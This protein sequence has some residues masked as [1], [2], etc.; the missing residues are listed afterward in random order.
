V[1]KADGSRGLCLSDLVHVLAQ[2]PDS[3]SLELEADAERLIHVDLLCRAYSLAGRIKLTPTAAERTAWRFKG[4]SAAPEWAVNGSPQAP[5]PNA[6]AEMVE[7]LWP[8]EGGCSSTQKDDGTLRGH[9]IAIVTNLP[10]HYRTALFAGLSRRLEATGAVLRVFFLGATARGR[11][12]LSDGEGLDFDHEFA[13]SISLPIRRQRAPFLPFNLRRLLGSF[14]PTIILAAG[15]SPFSTVEAA[16]HAG[17]RQI[18]FGIWS[19]ETP[20][21]APQGRR[22]SLRRTE[23]AWLARRASFGIAYGSLAAR[24]LRSLAP[25]LPVVLG[26]NTS[27]AEVGGARDDPNRGA[28][29]LVAVADLSVPGK[30]IETAVDAVGLVPDLP[31]RLSVIGG[32]P[33]KGSSL[34]AAARSRRV[35]F[36]GPMPHAH[37]KAAYRGSDVFLFPSLVDPFGLA[38]VEAMASE[39]AVITSP[40]PGAV[41]DLGVSGHNCLY[42]ARSRDARGQRSRGAGRWLTQSRR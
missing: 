1:W 41:A 40:A 31:C 18:P 19:G 17:R 21:L 16:L 38:L 6:M 42:V 25:A 30:G 2:L 24:Y 3:V 34:G 13:R 27:V 20:S 10:A 7:S 36:L 33:G 37:V 23:R 26:R 5:I 4:V 12:W 35:R 8:E 9:R 32:W 28:I 22:A 39:L 11:S 15:F 14:E 29:E